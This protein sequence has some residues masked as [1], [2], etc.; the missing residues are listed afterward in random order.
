MCLLGLVMVKL[1]RTYA[2]LESKHSHTVIQDVSLRLPSKMSGHIAVPSLGTS[3]GLKVCC[4]LTC[5]LFRSG[6]PDIFSKYIFSKWMIPG[7]CHALPRFGRLLTCDPTIKACFSR[8]FSPERRR[9]NQRDG[10]TLQP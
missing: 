4:F 8:F 10:R 1:W 6:H 3:T 7:I 9:S 5:L 2:G